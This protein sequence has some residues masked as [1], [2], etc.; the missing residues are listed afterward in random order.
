MSV[1]TNFGKSSIIIMAIITIVGCSGVQRIPE[2]K[3]QLSQEEIFSKSLEKEDFETAGRVCLFYDGNDKKIKQYCKCLFQEEL[4][5][6]AGLRIQWILA[7]SEKY[8]DQEFAVLLV[9]VWIDTTESLAGH[10]AF[11]TIL[12]LKNTEI[13][14]KVLKILKT[15][16]LPRTISSNSDE[17]VEFY[18]TRKRFLNRIKGKDAVLSAL[19]MNNYDNLLN[20]ALKNNIEEYQAVCLTKPKDKTKRSLNCWAILVPAGIF[21]A[22]EKSIAAINKYLGGE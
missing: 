21:V 22:E 10:L 5:H 14:R 12:R 13:G 1:I 9:S 16:A 8:S 11:D 19:E 17:V 2:S 18:K 3:P 6:N 7:D 20:R 15:D 4:K